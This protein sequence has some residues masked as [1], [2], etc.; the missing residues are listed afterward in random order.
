MPAGLAMATD[1][2]S[3]DVA[4]PAEPPEV[5]TQC[6]PPSD[7][8]SPHPGR[9]V[10]PTS[11]VASPKDLKRRSQRSKQVK[12]S[13]SARNESASSSP[14]SKQ[15]WDVYF[16]AYERSRGQKPGFDKSQGSLAGKAFKELNEVWGLESAIQIITNAFND[17]WTAANRCQPWEIRKDANKHAGNKPQVRRAGQQPNQPN[18]PGARLKEGMAF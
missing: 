3:G 2:P 11:D 9:S 12:V 10:T 16:Q 7:V 17:E 14:D 5:V 4:S 8:A 13:R 1:A 15:L 18:R 6:H